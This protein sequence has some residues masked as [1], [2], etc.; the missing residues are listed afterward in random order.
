MELFP[1]QVYHTIYLIIVSIAS[2]IILLKPQYIVDDKLQNPIFNPVYPLAVLFTVFIG[3]RPESGEFVDMMAYVV[4]WD[5]LTEIGFEEKTDNFIYDHIPYVINYLGFERRTFYLLIATIYFIGTAYA[6]QRLFGRNAIIAYI[7]WLGAFSTFSYGTNGIKAGSA[8]TVFIIAIS[9]YKNKIVAAI[10]LF[11]SLGLHHSMKLPIGA[12]ILCYFINDPKIWFK[13]W[14]ICLI[15]SVLH[16]TQIM[17]FLGEMIADSDD[18]G[19]G[20]LLGEQTNLKKGFRPDFLL[21]SSVP[22]LLG[23]WLIVKKQLQLEKYN[24]IWNIYVVCNSFWLLCMYASFTNRIAY[25]SWSIYPLVIIYPFLAKIFMPAQT[26]F[27]KGVIFYNLLFTLFM[28]IVY[29][30]GD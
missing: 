28:A 30:G 19:A 7:V 4:G 16:V 12:F 10:L 11:I 27:T 14:I 18:H 20:Y 26:G 29:Y 13:F 23:Y 25:L 17:E 22:V 24:F 6:C 1:A 5:W 8:A 15:L 3:F 21:Y 2:S 9:F